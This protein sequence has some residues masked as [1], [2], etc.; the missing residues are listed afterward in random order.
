MEVWPGNEDNLKQNLEC[1]TEDPK[2]SRK[3]DEERCNEL[4]KVVPQGLQLVDHLWTAVE[5]VAERVGDGLGLGMGCN[6]WDG[7]R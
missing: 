6:Q 3:K 5:I 4:H 1:S 2:G 7:I